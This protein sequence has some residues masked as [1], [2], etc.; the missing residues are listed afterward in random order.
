MFKEASK[1]G[2]VIASYNT[3][4]SYEKGVGIKKSI[5]KVG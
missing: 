1:L 2:N 4:V 5:L 3:G